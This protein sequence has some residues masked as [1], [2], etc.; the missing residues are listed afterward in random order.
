MENLGL[1][2]ALPV[3]VQPYPGDLLNRKRCGCE[4]R[5]LLSR[6]GQGGHKE[7][8]AQK[9]C[10]EPFP[11]LCDWMNGERSGLGKEE[12]FDVPCESEAPSVASLSVAFDQT[13]RRLSCRSV[14]GAF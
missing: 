3:V 4:R 12:G 11:C 13:D 9:T 7:I 5:I 6:E 14:A 10:Q 1:G 2:G 8:V